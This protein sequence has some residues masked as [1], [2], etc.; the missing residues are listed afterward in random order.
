MVATSDLTA[1]VGRRLRGEVER[2]RYRL[3]MTALDPGPVRLSESFQ[4]PVEHRERAALIEAYRTRFPSQEARELAAAARLLQHDIQ[5]LGHAMRFGPTLDWSRDPVSGRDWGRGFSRDIPYRGP[6]RL[7][8]IKLPWELNKH[9]YFFTLGKAA[10]L[11]GDARYAREIVA[12]IDHWI[13]ANPC[14]RGI[15]WVSALETGTRALSWMLAWPFFAAVSEPELRSR[16]LRSMA[17]HLLFVERNLSFDRFPNTHLVGEVAILAVGGLFLECRHSAR[18]LNL[19]MQ[20]LEAQMLEQVR[21]D[22]VH[23][24]QSVAYHRFFLDHYYLVNAI[25]TANGR[26]FSAEVLARLERMTGFLMDVMHPDGTVA[27]F[28]DSDDARG[29]WCRHD[30]P[31]DYRALLA[32]GAISFRRGDFKQIATQPAEELLWLHGLRGLREFDSLQSTAPNHTSSAYPDAGYYILRSGWDTEG[33]VCAFDCGPLGH[34][35]AGHG[36]ADALSFQL[37]ARGYPFL[38]DPG[39]YSYNLDYAVREAF[40]ASSAHNTITVDG[41]SQSTPKDRMSW[42]ASANARCLRWDSS[43][44]FDL[45]E[46]Q[47]DG[48]QRLPRPITH[49]RTVLYLKP[50]VWIV[51]DRLIGSG[52]D[53][54]FEYTLHLRPDCK[55][56]S[57]TPAA[58]ERLLTAPNGATLRF[59]WTAPTEWT[60][61]SGSREFSAA[62]GTRVPAPT[63]HLRATGGSDRSETTLITWFT[64]SSNVMLQAESVAEG[65]RLCVMRPGCPDFEHTVIPEL[66]S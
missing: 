66:E 32:L 24:E 62:Y 23:A 15:H 51:H 18:W 57:E 42:Q 61:D 43:A 10:W 48:Y 30:A 36:H 27:S 37:Y 6:Q 22:G 14:Q 50:D 17:Q 25:L 41:Q 52:P 46:G 5:L 34:G 1:R 4:H 31:S 65:L 21:S 40:R 7:G 63:L 3:G 53:H 38:I 2:V 56:S 59:S 45:V 26:S 54:Q 55:V 29:I 60:Y 16:M 64:T 8:D 28:G 9:Q 20:H 19:G 11:T 35:A 13:T 33:A 12:Q 39:T 44:L 47:H 58:R 49:R